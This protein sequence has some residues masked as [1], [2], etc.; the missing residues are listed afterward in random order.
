MA[1][2]KWAVTTVLTLHF[3]HN[4]GFSS[5][6]FYDDDY[7]Y[8]SGDMPS[9]DTKQ[10]HPFRDFC[11]EDHD[12]TDIF[13]K[14]CCRE[15]QRCCYVRNQAGIYAG[16]K[17]TCT[18][19]YKQYTG[20]TCPQS[21]FSKI[22]CCYEGYRCCSATDIMKMT[23]YPD[24]DRDAIDK[25]GVTSMGAIAGFVFLAVIVAG[26]LLTI[27]TRYIKVK[28][29]RQHGRAGIQSQAYIDA[30]N[31]RL[32]GEGNSGNNNSSAT[33]TND[34]QLPPDI[35]YISPSPGESQD[36]DEV[37]VG[38]PPTYEEAVATCPVVAEESSRQEQAQTPEMVR[39]QQRNFRFRPP[40]RPSRLDFIELSV[41]KNNLSSVSE[42]D[43][44][45]DTVTTIT[46]PK[47][48]ASNA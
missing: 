37:N 29:R 45:P 12:C 26:T 16:A 28:V 38:P 46:I 5:G 13:K 22:Y 2:Y 15:T 40:T 44:T 24:P 32:N 8:G 43:L 27:A 25:S 23:S 41:F 31:R 9:I 6:S 1:K 47:Q 4:A 18:N 20:V 14:Y 30:M 11:Y 39:P 3:L 21:D 42:D 34:S 17:R 10:T 48:E 36:L 33:G 7:Y 19:S 35:F